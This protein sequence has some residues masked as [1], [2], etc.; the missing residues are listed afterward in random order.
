MAHSAKARMG[1][2]DYE[3]SDVL[4]MGLHDEGSPIA[5]EARDE[6]QQ[7]GHGGDHASQRR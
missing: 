5:I 7:R 4:A 1:R 6:S 2:G 3:S